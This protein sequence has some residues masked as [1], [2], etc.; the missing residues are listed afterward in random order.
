MIPCMV[1]VLQPIG[2]YLQRIP[3]LAEGHRLL[4][5]SLVIK[6]PSSTGKAPQLQQQQEDSRQ[7]QLVS[8][9]VLDRL[10]KAGLAI[11]M[12]LYRLLGVKPSSSKAAERSNGGAL[13]LYAACSRA[14]TSTGD[15]I[16]GPPQQ[17]P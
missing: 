13:W 9:P 3:A 8:A 2:C 6:R 16:E 10:E 4:R 11:G 7:Q 12:R 14:G 15:D 5:L 17:H 1:Y